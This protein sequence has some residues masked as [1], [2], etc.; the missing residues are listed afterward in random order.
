MPE[1]HHPSLERYH[2]KRDFSVTAEP[3]GDADARTTGDSFVIQKHAASRLHYDFR[4]E[5]DGVLLSWSVPK[6]PSLV[7]GDRRLAVR[8][9]DHPLEYASFEGII[10]AG[11][12]GGGA[13]VVWDRG[14][15]ICKGDPR[16]GLAK[17]RLTFDLEGEK[18]AGRWHLVRTKGD[19]KAETWLLFKGRDAAASAD[20][21]TETR[22][23]SV[24]TGRTVEQVATDADK[25][26]RSNRPTTTKRRP[27][28][29]P[30]P[31]PRSDRDRARDLVSRLPVGFALTNLDKV[32][33]KEQGLTKA[34]VIAYLAV[35]ADAMLP[36][37]AGRPLMLLRCPDGQGAPCF[38]QKH[39][40][41]GQPE[42]VGAAIVEGDD[43]PEE[44]VKIEDAVGLI[45]I[46]QL[47]VLEIHT[48]AARADAVERPDRLVIDLDPDPSVKWTL[49]VEAAGMVRALLD[50]VGLTSFVTTTGGKGLHVVAPLRRRASWDEHKEF[51][52]AIAETIVGLEPHRYVAVASKAQRKGKIFVDYLRNGRG[53]TFIAPYSMRAR[54]GAPVA[55]PVTWEELD[56][57]DPASFTIE[58][59][60]PRIGS[61]AADPWAELADLKQ[62]ITATAWK[63]LGR[64]HKK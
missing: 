12:Y 14:R 29:R 21:I 31:K 55:T 25:V 6:G 17:G 8:T 20:D 24:V 46:G 15:W 37:V 19:G 62:G 11:E 13:V 39:T 2:A 34:D 57:I 10:P 54:P 49:V 18:L 40:L 60:P 1:A 32:L 26:W 51:A 44:H 9:E 42:G 22:P 50:E 16:D 23:E 41:R 61:L 48:W 63:R 56:T 28:E 52:R 3:R 33:Y 64:S 58:T 43:G 53:A 45:G 35:M 30:K 38:H 47:G 36:H 4:L 27:H 7:A 5:L 59:V